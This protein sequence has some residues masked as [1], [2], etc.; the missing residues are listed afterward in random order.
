[1]GEV[2]IAILTNSEILNLK[3]F[4]V[5]FTSEKERTMISEKFRKRVTVM[6][7]LIFLATLTACAGNR[8]ERA[9]GQRVRQ[10]GGPP[11][12]LYRL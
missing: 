9:G 12:E 10:Q 7:L 11:P 3:M 1:M 5:S 8:Q 2:T 4:P 6:I